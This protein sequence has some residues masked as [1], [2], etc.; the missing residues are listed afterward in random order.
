MFTRL[1]MV[2]FCLSVIEMEPQNGSQ[3]SRST[4]TADGSFDGAV[5]LIT[6]GSSGIGR[7]TAVTFG[8][9]GA[10]VVVASRTETNGE[11][12]VRLVEDAG[13]KA[14]FIETDVTSET[15]IERM[16]EHAVSTYGGIDYAVNNAGNMGVRGPLTDRTEEEWEYTM[17]VNL[18][19]VWL[20]MKHEIPHLRERGG[21][22]VNMASEFGHVGVEEFSLYVA[23]KHGVVGL[24]R[25][26]ALEYADQGIRVNAVSPAA[27]DTPMHRDQ[28]GSSEAVQEAFG[29]AH[30][31]GRVGTPKEVADATVWLCS[32][33]SS[34][35]TGHSLLI[36]GGFTAQ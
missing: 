16:V 7:A 9:E 27:I 29:P 2:L 8:R 33:K 3:E 24:T 30:P 21:A 19:G 4:T 14:T 36:D 26:A 20:S 23:S 22:I 1:I 6:G 34:F 13:G 32:D 35:V 25:A 17:G 18:K 5:T 10:N 12:T 28:F 31:L 11:E 15:D